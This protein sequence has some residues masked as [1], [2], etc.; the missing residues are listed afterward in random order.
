MS[1]FAVAKRDTVINL[2]SDSDTEFAVSECRW[3]FHITSPNQTKYLQPGEIALWDMT[4]GGV[5]YGYAGDWEV[6]S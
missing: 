5:C 1:Q 6:E 2:M 4:T 3:M